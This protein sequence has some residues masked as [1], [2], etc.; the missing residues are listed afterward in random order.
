MRLTSGARFDTPERL[1][2]DFLRA[3]CTNAGNRGTGGAML[4]KGTNEY[5]GQV[6]A[7]IPMGETIRRSWLAAFLSGR[8]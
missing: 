4:T 8:L 7:G 3:K 1:S 5:L 2:Y 6:G